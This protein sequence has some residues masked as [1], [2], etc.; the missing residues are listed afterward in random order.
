MTSGFARNA[1]VL[2]LL[3]AAGPI[4]TDMF[5]PALPF[6]T[7]DLNATPVAAQGSLAIFFLAVALFQ[8][9][10]G[11]VSDSFGRKPP[12][13]VGGAL[14]ALG[15]AGCGFAPSIE[16]LLAFRFIQG[17]GACASMSIPRAVVRDLHTGA[18][19]A[20]LMA[21]LLLVFSVGPILAPLAGSFFMAFA[22]WHY[23]FWTMAA[24]GLI[25]LVLTFYALQETRPP[26]QR[27]PFNARQITANYL[28]LFADRHYLGVA[29]ITG[30]S[31]ASFL[32]FL[33]GSSFVY[34]N[35]YG[36]TPT[37]YSLGFSLN[38]VA[39]IVTAQ[40]ASHLGLRFGPRRVVNVGLAAYLVLIVALTA[41]T[42]AGLDSLVAIMV[43]LFL[44]FSIVGIIVPTTQV[45]ALD[46]YGPTAGTA[47]AL[48]GTLQLV[49]GAIVV[50]IVGTFTD[51]TPAPMLV[52]M[53]VCAFIAFVIG[54]LTLSGP[55][56][57]P[58]LAE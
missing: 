53:A 57:A 1:L 13:Y 33:A 49:F 20:K 23:I 4:A 26:E 2:G 10:Y 8:V 56:P 12:L 41:A 29:S 40:F 55:E 5:L 42:F 43:V 7:R 15:A 9:V 16:W 36:L 46:N 3:S 22:T 31:M 39:F 44:G 24:V 54:R 51:G 11:P 48:M 58:Q 19:A 17:I 35:H 18:E 30:F 50:T 34:I 25:G 14:Y 28:Q 6:I 27:I 38:A 47:A 37:E 52:A 21:L 45:L 32:A